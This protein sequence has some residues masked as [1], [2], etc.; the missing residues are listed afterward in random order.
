M[1]NRVKFNSDDRFLLNGE[2]YR[3]EDV[4][5]GGL[6]L[7][8]VGNADITEFLSHQKIGEL[9]GTPVLKHEPGYYSR[10]RQLAHA[11]VEVETLRDLPDALRSKVLWKQA[12]CDVAISFFQGGQM[13]MTDESIRSMAPNIQ[14]KVNEISCKGQQGATRQYAGHITVARKPP[15]TSSLKRWLRCY[16]S[17][18]CSPITLIPG[19]FRSVVRC[20]RFC[21]ATET[22]LRKGIE[23]YADPQRPSMDLVISETQG[24]FR[25][26]NRARLERG[27][28]ALSVPSASTIRRRIRGLDPY[29]VDSKRYGLQW[30]NRKYALYENG[31]EASFPLERVE[32]DHYKLDVVSLLSE[33]GAL[34]GLSQ[35][36]LS[37]IERGRRWVCVASD[38]ATRC[39]VG[40]SL[41]DS[42]STASAIRTL[43]HITMDKPA[44]AQGLGCEHGWEMHGTP[45]KVVTDQGSEFFSVDFQ[46]KVGGLNSAIE[47]SPAGL[48]HLRGHVERAFRTFGSELMPLLA[49]RTFSNSKERGDYDAMGLASLSD[50]DLLEVLVNF[51]VDIYHQ[52]PHAGLGGETPSNAWKRLT[53]KYGVTPAPDGYARRSVFG[54]EF[55]RK[56]T[57]GNVRFLGIT[58]TNEQMREHFLRKRDRTVQ[59]RVDQRDLG[60]VSVQLDGKWYPAQATLGSFDNMSAR[61]WMSIT[62]ALRKDSAAQ[63]VLTESSI[64]KARARISDVQRQAFAR[65]SLTPRHL[66]AED[67]LRSEN[68]LYI[69]LS[70]RGAGG[71]SVEPK[72]ADLLEDA[73]EIAPAEKS[74]AADVSGSASI[75]SI[76][77]EAPED[78]EPASDWCL[79]DD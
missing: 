42:P 20:K 26:E 8:Q 29:Y 19:T 15:S 32:I 60:W 13:K 52:K 51:I 39:I 57:G 30:A 58:Y 61:E 7:R 48:P 69:G 6:L 73:I 16:Q 35:E 55:A 68:A 10:E 38:V 2:A 47:Y 44:L 54:T 9:W 74:H 79:E 50:D 3:V 11:N 4:S 72:S 41:T 77:S 75:A 62:L 46:T 17:G 24:M 53:G 28:S 37:A 76:S 56:I 70:L 22:L 5:V 27:A 43:E 21:P 18:G 33:S 59:I 23:Q 36:Q 78:D 34:H 63:A 1:S 67:I 49:G 64:I 14:A 66:S 71:S 40:L 65:L 45:A 31:V 12:Y 25:K